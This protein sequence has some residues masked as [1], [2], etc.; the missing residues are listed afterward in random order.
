MWSRF[1][2]VWNLIMNTAQSEKK[3]S[4]SNSQLDNNNNILLL[5]ALKPS[6]SHFLPWKKY[7]TCFFSN[8]FQSLVKGRKWHFHLHLPLTFLHVFHNFVVKWEEREKWKWKFLFLHLF[9]IIKKKKFYAR[10]RKQRQRKKKSI[11]YQEGC[12]IQAN[13]TLTLN[14]LLMSR[15]SRPRI[16]FILHRKL[17]GVVEREKKAS[18]QAKFQQ[19]NTSREN[20]IN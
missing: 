17:I 12:K 18:K 16:F 1:W 7:S 4:S 2:N 20:L 13:R 6:F 19:Q 14:N 9:W 5:F 10:T 3:T 15:F 11:F 8:N